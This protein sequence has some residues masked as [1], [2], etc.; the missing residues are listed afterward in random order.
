M[1]HRG[2]PPASLLE[3]DEEEEESFGRLVFRF[4][5]FREIF[6]CALRERDLPAFPLS[7]FFLRVSLSFPLAPILFCST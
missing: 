6:S 3:D 2:P 7:Y 1:S 5:A 4:S